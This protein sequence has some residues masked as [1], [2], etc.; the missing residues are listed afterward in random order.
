MALKNEQRNILL[1]MHPLHRIALSLVLT[2]AAYFL[3]PKEDMKTMVVAMILWV[4]FSFSYIITNWIVIFTRPVPEIRKKAM[5]DD[6]S[7]PFVFF[8]VLIACFASMFTVLLLMISRNGQTNSQPLSI[9]ASI[10]GMLLSWVLVHTIFTFHYAH[11]YYDS[12]GDEKTK[13][14]GGLEFPGSEKPDYVDFAYFSFV[15]GCTFQVS[16]VEIS[17]R[18]IRRIVLLH[19]LISFALNTFVV[20]LTINFVGSLMN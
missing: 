13:I 10:T 20:A 7:A 4:V 11:E 18:K 15:I 12:D 8:M 9:V 17:S 19:G 1:R 2:A 16:D 3:L 5:S 14:A 6:G